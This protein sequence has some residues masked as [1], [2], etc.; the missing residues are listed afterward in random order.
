M[1]KVILVVSFGTSYQASLEETI[2]A[3]ERSIGTAF[4]EWEVRRAFTSGMVIRKLRERD[5]L[6]VDNVSQAMERLAAD[7]AEAV[8]VQ[9]TH[10]ISG[11]EYDDMVA[12][13]NR[14]ANRFESLR[15][16]APLLSSTEDYQILC[17]ALADALSPPSDT[18]LVLMGHGTAHSA[19]AVYAALAYHFLEL[20]KE[21]FVVGTV[22]GYPDLPATV[23]TVLS[24]GFRKVMLTPLMVVSG[25]HANNDLAGED[26]DSWKSVFEA[27]GCHV[28]CL[29]KGLGQY[30]AIREL[31][32]AHVRRAMDC[33]KAGGC[34][35]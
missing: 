11:F 16:G 18:A 9:P 7:G 8:V 20:G 6:S 3:V 10:V 17:T 13:V 33:P 4:P 25:D 19:N 12:E 32:T 5:G 21:N 31:Y 24:R 15:L 22:E 2:G 35:H 30:P 14:W 29:L 27:A 26:P 28:T 34:H 1:K 23:K